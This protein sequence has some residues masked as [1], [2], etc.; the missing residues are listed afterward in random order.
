MHFSVAKDLGLG[1]LGLVGKFVLLCFLVGKFR[2]LHFSG[3]RALKDRSMIFI[4]EELAANHGPGDGEYLF[5]LDMYISYCVA[6]FQQKKRS[7]D[8][9]AF[10]DDAGEWVRKKRNI[11]SGRH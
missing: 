1:A 5:P 6:P 10:Q 3:L 8:K 4:V 9:V 7:A 2:F 11:F